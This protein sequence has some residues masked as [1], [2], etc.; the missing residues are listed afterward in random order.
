M[1]DR[2][3]HPADM[4]RRKC[5]LL[6]AALSALPRAGAADAPPVE[7]PLRA[8][9]GLPALGDGAKWR[10]TYIDFWASWCAPC[11]L[12]F[13]WM[14]EMHDRYADKGLRIVAVGL[15][16]READAQRFLQQAQPRFSIALDPAAESARRLD[17]QAMPSSFLFS[18]ERR[19]I[20]GH[21][22]F[23]LEDRAGL[24]GRL[25]AALA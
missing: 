16:R 19:L 4:R 25:R 11:R 5:L 7:L 1:P 3:L 6:A 2:D 24:E 9:D 12:S 20:F 18:S 21:R 15:D 17:V 22:G 10:A 14:N 8:S 13:P 23:R